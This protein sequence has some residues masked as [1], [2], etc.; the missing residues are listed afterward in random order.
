[1]KI[2]PTEQKAY[3]LIFPTAPQEAEISLNGLAAVLV[4]DQ[5]SGWVMREMEEPALLSEDGLWPVRAE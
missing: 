4:L 2:S 1:M 3:E 5:P